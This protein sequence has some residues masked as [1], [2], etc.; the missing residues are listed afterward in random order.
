M[1][2]AFGCFD[3]GFAVDLSFL[4]TSNLFPNHNSV[5]FPA[6]LNSGCVLLDTV[7]HRIMGFLL[8]HS[9]CEGVP[10]SVRCVIPDHGIIDDRNCFIV[11]DDCGGVCTGHPD[12]PVIVHAVEIIPGNDNSL[13]CVCMAS[14]IDIDPA[15]IAGYD[16]IMAASPMAVTVIC[17]MRR[18]WHP[19]HIGVMVN[20]ENSSGKPKETDIQQGNANAHLHYRWCPI[21]GI[22][23]IDPV[24]V[25]VS[26]VP[27]R[28][29]GDPHLIPIPFGPATS[30]EGRPSRG[31]GGRPPEPA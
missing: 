22:T 10:L 4:S 16:H 20:P 5:L 28:F 29:C 6:P 24:A 25:V 13:S 8:C 31:Y 2:Y 21:P 30:G 15:D 11:I 18:Q 17:L 3:T 26:D 19:S 7:D 9:A 14:D 27:E 1:A 12:I 23:C